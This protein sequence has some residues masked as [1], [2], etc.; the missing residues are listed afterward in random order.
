MVQAMEREA[1]GACSNYRSCEA[2]CPKEISIAAIAKMNRD[3]L[4]AS[5]KGRKTARG[6]RGMR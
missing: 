1:F 5:L 6:K 4:R 2:V 3:Y